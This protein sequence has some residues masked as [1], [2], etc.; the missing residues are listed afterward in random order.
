MMMPAINSKTIVETALAMIDEERGI[1]GL[2]LRRLA[3]VLGCAHTNIYNYFAGMEELLWECVAEASR[4]MMAV[5]LDAIDAADGTDKVKSLCEAYLD[6]YLGHPGLFRLIWLEDLDGGRPEK[7]VSETRDLISLM[8]DGMIPALN[9]GQDR[10]K[11]T[12]IL[13][14]I[15]CYLFGEAAIFLS[16][17]G[18]IRDE[19]A[20]RRHVISECAARI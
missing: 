14:N 7:D 1:A 10:E 12:L 5:V 9:C 8:I 2:N 11:A 16:G 20:F 18:L 17:R 4:R 3:R 19:A 6:F 13:H 15:H